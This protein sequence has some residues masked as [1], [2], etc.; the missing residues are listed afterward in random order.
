[1]DWVEATFIWLR[2]PKWNKSGQKMSRTLSLL[3]IVSRSSEVGQLCQ[4]LLREVQRTAAVFSVPYR[5]IQ[6]REHS[7][8]IKHR[9]AAK[10]LDMSI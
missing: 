8:R 4:E 2:K 9:R 5:P 3:P 6:R 1:M 7:S 10:S